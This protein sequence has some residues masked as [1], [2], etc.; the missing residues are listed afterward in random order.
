MPA[1]VALKATANYF[2]WDLMR[3]LFTRWWSVCLLLVVASGSAWAGTL[4]TLRPEH[5]RVLARG[6]DFERIRELVKSDELSTRWYAG[7][8]ERGNEMLDEPVAKRELRD[9][10]RLSYV[11]SDV[12]DRVLALSMLDRL[13][14]NDAYRD[15]VW[16]D[17]Q[18]AAAFS[19][20]NPDHFLD[21]AIMSFAFAIAY[22][23]MYDRWTPEQRQVIRGA[24]IELAIKP[25]L[26]AHAEGAWWTRTH[27]NWNQVCHG[28]LIAGALAIADEEPAMA[29]QMVDLGVKALKVPMARYAPDGGYDEG[30]SYWGFG[31]GYNVIALAALESAL[32]TDLGLGEM[33]GFSQTGLFPVQMTGPTDLAYNFGDAKEGPVQSPALFYFA[34]RF[35]H[36][37]CA[38]YALQRNIGTALDLL[39]YDPASLSKDAEPLPLSVMFRASSV[40]VMRSGWGPDDW[41]VGTKGGHLDYGHAQ[42]DLGSFVLDHAGVRWLIDLGADDYNLDGYFAS[43]KNG[44]RWD[45]Y[46]ARAEGHNTLVINPGAKPDQAYEARV[47][48]EL[49]GD[50]VRIDL[51]SA[52]AARVDRAITLDREHD[53]VRVVDRLALEQA[54]EL[55][56]FAHTRAQVE[57]AADGRSALLSQDGKKLRARV[58]SPDAA[59]FTVMDARPLPTSPDPKGQ[60]PNNGAGKTNVAKGTKYVMRGETPIYGDPDAGSAIRKLAI[61][62]EGVT[63]Q[64]IEVVFEEEPAALP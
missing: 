2:Y 60:N 24:L 35:R 64:V 59:R 55:W 33:P 51:S 5:P 36:P 6:E 49:D 39:W 48:I 46:R 38:S 11:S 44:K 43:Y 14:P 52:Y 56:W 29:R 18:A 45:Y 19:D 31:T 41:F 54:S 9:G 37:A 47:P 16:A 4:D 26:S 27:I 23:W 7:L 17:M 25:G 12:L 10:R 3:Y 21:V 42:M 53:V 30:P 22:D 8:K 1:R 34:N 62:L 28:G 50:T 58:V 32:G 61:H 63:R 13:E 57:V 40:A 20:W 15:R